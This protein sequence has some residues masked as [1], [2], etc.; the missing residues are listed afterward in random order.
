[1]ALKSYHGYYY[2]IQICQALF[3]FSN[4]L[5]VSVDLVEVAL[6][7]INNFFPLLWGHRLPPVLEKVLIED[8]KKLDEKVLAQTQIKLSHQG[9]TNV[10]NEPILYSFRSAYFPVVST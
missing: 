2:L 10:L 5:K 1:M 9:N 3:K 7:Q 6:A 4:L 8:L